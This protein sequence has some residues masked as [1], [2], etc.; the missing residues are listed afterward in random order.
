LF[1]LLSE[2]KSLLTDTSIF[3]IL[4]KV[5]KKSAFYDIFLPVFA[6]F[7][8]ECLFFNCNALKIRDK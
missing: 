6:N 8:F 1:T 7:C 4:T 3:F 5:S 2:N